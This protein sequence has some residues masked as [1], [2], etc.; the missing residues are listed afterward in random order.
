MSLIWMYAQTTRP[1]LPL[2]DL[3]DDM[4]GGAKAVEPQFVASTSN[5]ERTS[6]DQASAEQRGKSHVIA[7]FAERERIA[8]VGDRRRC[9]TAVA[10]VPSEERAIAEILLA[11]PAIGADAAGVAEPRNADALTQAQPFDASPDHIDPADDLVARNDRH[12]RV[13]QFPIDDMQVRA[14]DAARGHLDSNLT[15]PR[16]P[17]GEICPFKR[18]PKLL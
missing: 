14:A 2:C 7:N 9:E 1:P 10:R 12:L 4:G 6:A 5:H 17:I 11:A 8:R 15:R 16:L 3:S 13:G 18:S